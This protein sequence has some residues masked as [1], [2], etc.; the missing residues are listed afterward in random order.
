MEYYV[1]FPVPENRVNRG[2]SGPYYGFH[3]TRFGK[4][5]GHGGSG[6]LFEI[7]PYS[8]GLFEIN[9]YSSRIKRN[10]GTDLWMGCGKIS[11]STYNYLII[12]III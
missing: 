11:L 4:R 12:T 3:T 2:N 8:S 9:P 5:F 6:G 10:L 7:N 1:C